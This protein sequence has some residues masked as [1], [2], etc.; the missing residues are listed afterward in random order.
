MVIHKIKEILMGLIEELEKV[1]LK[2]ESLTIKIEV[3][4]QNIE[5]LKQLVGEENEN[6]SKN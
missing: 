4:L 2:V 6:K 1:E 5:E 3:L